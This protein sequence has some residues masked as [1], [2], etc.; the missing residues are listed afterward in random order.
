MTLIW[1][2]FDSMSVKRTIRVFQQTPCKQCAKFKM[3]KK[4]VFVQMVMLE[5]ANYRH[6]FD[7]RRWHVFI[8]Y[9][10]E[11][12]PQK[13]TGCTDIDECSDMNDCKLESNCV[14]EPGDFY[15][16]CNKGYQSPNARLED[17]IDINECE[18]SVCPA[19]STCENLNGTY[20]CECFD[21]YRQGLKPK[22]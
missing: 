17:C 13:G 3:A 15:C 14:N 12:E 11:I 22:D 21:G 5:M 8:Y 20:Y 2:P 19:E 1:E 10:I 9:L 18:S 16:A 7:R 4:S 6:G